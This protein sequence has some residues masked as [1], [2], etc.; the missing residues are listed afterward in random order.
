MSDQGDYDP[1]AEGE[2]LPDADDPWADDADGDP[3]DDE[4]EQLA[5]DPEAWAEALR[6]FHDEVAGAPREVSRWQEAKEV[7]ARA[8]EKLRAF[9][10]RYG[11]IACASGAEVY[12]VHL[13][14]PAK[15]LGNTH[16]PAGEHCW[17]EP[18]T[19]DGVGQSYR[20]LIAGGQPWHRQLD[21]DDLEVARRAPHIK[22]TLGIS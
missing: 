15:R 17:M 22:A 6:A 2:D 8:E 13:A 18:V 7:R 10:R 12:G 16:D 20:M 4:P 14:R 5:D 3:W 1:W 21:P 11:L 9:A 19:G